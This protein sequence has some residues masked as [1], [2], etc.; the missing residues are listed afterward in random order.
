MTDA[1]HPPLAI[2]RDRLWSTILRSAE[3]G[4]GAAGGLRR[5]ALSDDDRA[6][7]DV[8][9][10]WCEESGLAVRI[11]RAGNMFARL[12]GREA[13]PP[14]LVG[15]HLDSQ[16][17]GGRFDGVVGVLAGLEAVR[18]IQDAGITPR[19][20]IEVVNWTNEEGARF[21]PPMMA[22]A[23]FAGVQ[24][25]AWLDARTDAD[26]KAVADELARIGYRGDAPVGF[27]IDSYLE[28][29]IEQG[30]ELDAAGLALGVVTGGYPTRGLRVR[31][32]G[33]TAHTGPTPMDRRRD[34]LV[35]ASLLAT[36]VFEL[37]WR[38]A[39][40]GKATTTAMELW[41]N[42]PGLVTRTATVTLDVRHAD[43]ATALA[44]F[45]EAR[46]AAHAA[47]A[48]AA[49]AVEELESW[50][51][52]D[53]RFDP[54]LIALV[55]RCT[56]ARGVAARRMA[57]QAGHDAYHLARVAPTLMLFC[58]CRD[59]VTHNEAEHC[60]PADVTPAAEV[61]ADAVLARAER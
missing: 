51:F 33:D 24:D 26:G 42:L 47:G 35:A 13:L 28:L 5:L 52:G 22:S 29:H 3:I 11:D 44:M 16:I 54:E 40:V 49:C 18:A 19:R 45:E 9:R 41:P 15:S 59:G 25:M 39:P 8:F 17:T 7:R 2:D 58:P 43:E 21:S 27:A 32:T 55:E 23:V 37:G 4:P 6:M 50:R 31:F 60:D 36:A 57:S 1:R 30:P 61:L 10:G 48:R 38:R 20:P 12:A 56:A 34:A 53:E 14:V 46:R